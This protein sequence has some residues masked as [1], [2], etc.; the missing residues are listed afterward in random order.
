[1]VRAGIVG[2]ALARKLST[3]LVGPRRRARVTPTATTATAAP[4][5]SQRRGPA[6]TGEPVVRGQWGG[7]RPA[8]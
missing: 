2:G 7:L 1:M 3:V 4:T 6:P 8:A 5:R